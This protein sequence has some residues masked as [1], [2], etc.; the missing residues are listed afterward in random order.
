MQ[1]SGSKI[2]L[3]W[4]KIIQ[5]IKYIEVYYDIFNIHIEEVRKRRRC[6]IYVFKYVLTFHQIE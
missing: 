6:V 5:V 3:P 2:D 4:V 1:R